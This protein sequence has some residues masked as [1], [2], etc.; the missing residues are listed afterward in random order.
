MIPL[1]SSCIAAVSYDHAARI[2]RI[3]FRNG[4]GIYSYYGVPPH[5]FQGLLKATSSHGGYYHAH[6][7]GRY[8]KPGHPPED[9]FRFLR[10]PGLPW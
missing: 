5:I 9:T 3:R 6:I 8:G 2:L 1:D 10:A 7:K 4:G